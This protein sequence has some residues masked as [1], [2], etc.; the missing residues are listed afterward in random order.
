MGYKRT[1][2]FCPI[3][4]CYFTFFWRCDRTEHLL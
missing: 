4:W 1:K 2:I 3:K